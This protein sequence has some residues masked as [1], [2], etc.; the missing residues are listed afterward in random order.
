MLRAAPLLVAVAAAARPYCK[1][2]HADHLQAHR[3]PTDYKLALLGIYYNDVEGE[4]RP[5][6]ADLR[7]W[8]HNDAAV[9]YLEE[10]SDGCLDDMTV[11]FFVA[12]NGIGHGLGA[13]CD[14]DDAWAGA[15]ALHVDEGTAEF[16]GVYMG[17]DLGWPG[18]RSAGDGDDACEDD[19]AWSA[20]SVDCAYVAEDPAARCG[21]VEAAAACPD[22]TF[23]EAQYESTMTATILPKI[24]GTNQVEGALSAWIDG[25]VHAQ[26]G[27]TDVLP[28]GPYAGQSVHQAMIYGGAAQEDGAIVWKLCVDGEIYASVG[29]ADTFQADE[30]LG[31]AT[32]PTVVDF[33]K[34][35]PEAM[36]PKTCGA[37]SALASTYMHELFH[38]MGAQYHATG[39]VCHEPERDFQDLLHRCADTNYGDFYDVMGSGNGFAP[40]LQAAIR[41][42]MGWMGKDDVE[43]VETSGEYAIYPLNGGPGSHNRTDPKKRALFFATGPGVPV[44]LTLEWRTHHDAPGVS[45]AV[46]ERNPGFFVRSGTA[47]VDADVASCEPF[48]DD[49]KL[50]T[51]LL[52][53]AALVLHMDG[54]VV[55]ADK[56]G[57]RDDGT[58]AVEIRFT[59][60][61][62]ECHRGL[63]AMH[64]GHLQRRNFWAPFYT[65]HDECLDETKVCDD[66]DF[67]GHPSVGYPL[68][69]DATMDSGYAYPCWDKDLGDVP[70]DLRDAHHHISH[71]ANADRDPGCHGDEGEFDIELVASTLDGV[72]FEVQKDPSWYSQFPMRRLNMAPGDGRQVHFAYGIPDATPDGTYDSCISIT[73]TFTGLRKGFLHRLTLGQPFDEFRHNRL[74]SFG[75]VDYDGDGDV[76][77]GEQ[78]LFLAIEAACDGL[79]GCAPGYPD[80]EW[81]WHPDFCH[82]E[83]EVACDGADAALGTEDR[84]WEASWS[85][86]DAAHYAYRGRDQCEN[87]GAFC[88]GGAKILEAEAC[89]DPLLMPCKNQEFCFQDT[90]AWTELG[91]TYD[92]AG[93]VVSALDYDAD[94]SLEPWATPGPCQTAWTL[95]PLR[96]ALPTA[97]VGSNFL[98]GEDGAGGANSLHGTAFCEHTASKA[99]VDA[100]GWTWP[101]ET[102]A[103]P[104]ARWAG[105]IQEGHACW[106]QGE[107]DVEC[108]KRLCEET[109]ECGGLTVGWRGLIGRPD[110]DSFNNWNK[111][112]EGSGSTEIACLYKPQ[113]SSTADECAC[114]DDATWYHTN[115]KNKK[116]DCVSVARN[117]A[118]RCGMPGAKAACPATCGTC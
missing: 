110:L 109:D 106:A 81:D 84:C 88:K 19:A 77:A 35:T 99:D 11:E 67:R 83:D 107:P 61:R 74:A 50:R 59:G 102:A 21:D 10:V 44:H 16:S 68:T 9:A 34:E 112:G 15:I 116:L 90:T 65:C 46:L 117:P 69:P 62:Q 108:A 118:R 104:H 60:E 93:R 92:Y 80:C 97:P 114:A 98:C 32:S 55:K 87:L 36:C 3:V 64:T 28:F 42:D 1:E 73:N 27:G 63:P 94:A 115:K 96:D 45:A 85:P 41:Y 18:W 7:S 2:P 13:G 51:T 53:D 76:S 103:F 66:Y 79:A 26:S 58:M 25:E 111:R 52:P 31:D 43:F 75:P 38:M 113:A 12:E 30:T 47:L 54:T 56:E 86:D 6:E 37:C 39:L 22:W 24:G 101:E 40:N 33:V 100:F 70:A 91:R 71:L 14:D 29:S 23:N 20:G 4:D 89:D 49:E 78:G 57:P 17:R 72:G 5:T 105:F 48:G 95:D 82:V 8:Y